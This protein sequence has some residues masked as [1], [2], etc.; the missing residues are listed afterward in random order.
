MGKIIKRALQPNTSPG[1]R[2]AERDGVHG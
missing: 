2:T 1:S